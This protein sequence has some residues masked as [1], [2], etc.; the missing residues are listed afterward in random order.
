MKRSADESDVSDGQRRKSA[1]S[2]DSGLQRTA[3]DNGFAC[4]SAEC[5]GSEAD[6]RDCATTSSNVKDVLRT[7]LLQKKTSNS[8]EVA[9]KAVRLERLE[10]WKRCFD[11]SC[12]SRSCML[13]FRV[14]LLRVCLLMI[15]L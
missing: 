12:W 13:T 4:S 6:E 7:K 2:L 9:A 14:W 3:V 11:D 10:K 5:E 8:V 15:F 1:R